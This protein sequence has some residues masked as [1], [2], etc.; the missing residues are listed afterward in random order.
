M[1]QNNGPA[2]SSLPVSPLR[3]AVGIWN[4]PNVI[5]GTW[6]WF[7]AWIAIASVSRSASSFAS[8]QSLVSASI[9]GLSYQPN[10]PAAPTPRN[11]AVTTGFSTEAAVPQVWN[12]DQPPFSTGSRE[13]G[14]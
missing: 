5:V 12:T 14:G 10:Q 11:A 13:G 2:A 9:F 7:S 6:A 4:C 8:S 1:F 3:Y